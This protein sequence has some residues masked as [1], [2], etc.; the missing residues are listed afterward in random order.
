MYFS[1][2]KHFIVNPFKYIFT[3][4]SLSLSTLSQKR[5]RGQDQKQRSSFLFPILSTFKNQ[6]H[7]SFSCNLNT[8]LNTQLY[9]LSPLPSF[10]YFILL[11]FFPLFHF[12]IFKVSTKECASCT[13]KIMA[14]L[15]LIPI[16]YKSLGR[17][18]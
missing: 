12:C 1:M 8:K 2:W 18:P 6:F 7:S 13:L 11:L 5:K 10:V 3:T 16:F 17:Y 15:M 4:L 9:S 14:T